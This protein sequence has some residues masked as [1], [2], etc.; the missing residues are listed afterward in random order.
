MEGFQENSWGQIRCTFVSSRVYYV[1]HYGQANGSLVSQTTVSCPA[2]SARAGDD[3]QNVDGHA[4]VAARRSCPHHSRVC[5]R[6]SRV[7]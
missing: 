4:Y 5:G 1:Y 6:L 3:L 2:R 7:T